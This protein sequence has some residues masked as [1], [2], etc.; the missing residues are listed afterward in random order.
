MGITVW[1]NWKYIKRNKR[2]KE[3]RFIVVFK[4]GD[5]D[6]KFGDSVSEVI[7]M[8]DSWKAEQ[9]VSIVNIPE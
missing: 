9:V 3:L 5:T 1:L 7:N 4:D 8:M 2:V 6:V